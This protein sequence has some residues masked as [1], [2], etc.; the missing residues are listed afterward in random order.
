[1][2]LAR[3][4]GV[5]WWDEHVLVVEKPAGLVTHPAY[6]H[7]DDTLT[8]AVWAWCD[9]RRWERPWLLH[10]LD[11][12]T[13]GLV[14]FARSRA[15]LRLGSRQFARHAV[16][17]QYDA[18]T[19]RGD[20]AE[21]GVI[22]AP[23]R[24]DPA[25]RR[26]VHI[27][28]AGAAAT[29]RYAVLEPLGALALVRLWPRTGRMHQLRVHLAAHGAPILGDP[30]YNP[31]STLEGPDLLST[32]GCNLRMWLHASALTLC[33]PGPRGVR[34]RTFLSPFPS[35]G[36]AVLAALRAAAAMSNLAQEYQHQM[37][38]RIPCL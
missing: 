32:G 37:E 6:R 1:M 24:R 7:P 34:S 3:S 31:N 38:E 12:D 33:L 19:R 25:D 20:L 11:R 17:K 22:D 5:V 28:P 4:F 8:D 26:R 10:R 2:T 36:I 15:A 23:L 9:A 16:C 13:S 18:L 35:D 27:D 29:T 21:D 30:V 14:L